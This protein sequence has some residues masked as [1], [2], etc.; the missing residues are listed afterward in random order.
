MVVTRLCIK[1]MYFPRFGLLM[2][3]ANNYI[4]ELKYKKIITL[5]LC[6]FCSLIVVV[7]QM[8]RVIT[9]RLV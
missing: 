8:K 6:M 9:R 4:C 2:H 1:T 3:I 7:A 5:F